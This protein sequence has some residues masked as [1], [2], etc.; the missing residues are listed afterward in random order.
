MRHALAE[1]GWLSMMARGAALERD[2]WKFEAFRAQAVV[3]ASERYAWW[4]GAQVIAD[5]MLT[6]LELLSVE[7]DENSH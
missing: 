5:E 6:T 4:P 2:A 7:L 3:L 1:F